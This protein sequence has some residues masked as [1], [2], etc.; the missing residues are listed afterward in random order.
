MSCCCLALRGSQC[1]PFVP[2]AIS[3]LSRAPVWQSAGRKVS[4]CG[5]A[6]YL[7]DEPKSEGACEE[8]S[9]LTFESKKGKRRTLLRIWLGSI[10]DTPRAYVF[11]VKTS[12]S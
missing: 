7:R 12:S 4:S 9:Q 8:A 10:D 1:I 3:L 11:V 2:F 5:C 6:N